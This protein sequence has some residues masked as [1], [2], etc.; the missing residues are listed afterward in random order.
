DLTGSGPR[1][2]ILAL[3]RCSRRRAWPERAR[4][5]LLSK[6][7]SLPPGCPRNDA[8]CD[9]GYQEVHDDLE[10]VALYAPG[11]AGPRHR[12][13]RRHDELRKRNA[14]RQ[15]RRGVQGGSRHE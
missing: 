14:A 3:E 15:G 5:I 4:A 7:V 1:T 9:P 6:T 11:D 2:S 12:G 8:L 13:W 10:T